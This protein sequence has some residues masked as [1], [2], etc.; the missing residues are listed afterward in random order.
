MEDIDGEG[1][2]GKW[3]ARVIQSMLTLL[4]PFEN[5]TATVSVHILMI[6]DGDSIHCKKERDH[7]KDLE[8]ILRQERQEVSPVEVQSKQLKVSDLTELARISTAHMCTISFASGHAP[9]VD[10]VN[11]ETVLKSSE[12]FL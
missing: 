12:A 9:G 7:M 3:E 11:I 6:T 4:Q 8:G 2:F 1:W 5:K 10:V